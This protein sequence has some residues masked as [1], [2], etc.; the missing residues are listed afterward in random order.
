[1][2]GVSDSMKDIKRNAVYLSRRNITFLLVLFDIALQLTIIGK[3]LDNSIMSAYAPT[4]LD[5]SEYAELAK[6]W[7]EE[8]FYQAFSDIWRM[9]GY[10]AMILTMSLIFPSFPFLAMRIVQMFALAISVAMIKTILDK[11]VGPRLSISLTILY[12][13]LPLWHF[14]PV[15]IAE[16]LTSFFFVCLLYVLASIKGDKLSPFQAIQISI[17]LAIETYLKPNLISLFL[18]IS[19]FLIFKLR[20][21]FMRSLLSIILP[22]SFLLLPWIVFTNSVEPEFR[23]LTTTFGVNTYVGTGM[24]LNYDTGVLAKSA[25]RRGVDPKSNPEDVLVMDSSLTRAQQSSILT[26]KSIEIW[27]KRPSK[28]V[29]FGFDKVLIA[30]GILSSSTVEHVL[31]I[32]SLLT[33]ISSL[34]LIRNRLLRGWGWLLLSLSTILAFQA[35]FIQADRRFVFP[36]FFPISII[37]IAFLIETSFSEKIQKWLVR[38]KLTKK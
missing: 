6:I 1:M 18:P 19:I 13:F 33:V 35:F 20:A 26:S 23:G 15:L 36:L 14:V 16:S 10:P 29:T 8:G 25:V 28:Q 37:V 32:F 34:A 17:L 31:G 9:P 30:F 27:K 21:R 7:K 22:I 5:A 3:Y 12:I 24:I 38:K 2:R 11:T 4:A